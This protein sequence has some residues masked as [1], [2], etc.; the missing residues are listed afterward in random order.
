MTATETPA[1]AGMPMPKKLAA[2]LVK[3]QK[4]SKPVEKAQEM[5]GARFSYKFAGAEAIIEEARRCMAEAG[6][7]VFVANWHRTDR[8]L[9]ARFCLV[10]ESGESWLSEPCM[11]SALENAGRP[12]DKAE[13]SALTY[14]TNYFLTRLLNLPRIE[15]D[16]AARDD[17]DFVP[18]KP[19]AVR[20]PKAQTNLP[21][22]DATGSHTIRFGK[23]KGQD[24]AEVARNNRKDAE[25]YYG[26]I[27]KSTDDPAKARFR[28][29]NLR[30]LNV[31]GSILNNTEEAPPEYGDDFGQDDIPF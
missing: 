31:L 1:P 3:A 20:S 13:A 17:S 26:A 18:N 25:W 22:V 27:A 21:A 19:S 6:L 2:A 11:F 29:D 15:E 12:A 28:D 10:H 7:G 8:G 9:Q 24:F 14:I 5:K 30:T 4:L 16:V 23:Q